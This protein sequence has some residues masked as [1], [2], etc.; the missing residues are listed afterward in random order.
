MVVTAVVFYFEMLLA[1][2]QFRPAFWIGD[3]GLVD[4]DRARMR[5]ALQR[6]VGLRAGHIVLARRQGHA[7]F[8]DGGFRGRLHQISPVGGKARCSNMPALSA[9]RERRSMTGSASLLGAREIAVEA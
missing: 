7:A 4:L 6:A 5:S 8:S 9:D 1:D 3:E 2:L